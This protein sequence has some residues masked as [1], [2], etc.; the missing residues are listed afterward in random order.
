M[1]AIIIGAGVGG[2]AAASRLSRMGIEVSIYEKR[3]ITGGRLSRLQEK[4]FRIDRGPTLLLMPHLFKEFFSDIGRNIEDYLELT[5]LDPVYR[6][7]F[8]DGSVIEPSAFRKTMVSTISKI[9]KEDAKNYC[10]FISD[11]QKYYDIAM[12]EFIMKNFDSPLDMVTPA[13]LM[14][15]V[16]GGAFRDLYSKTGDYFKD[17]RVRVAFSIQSIYLGERPDSIPSVYGIIP[18]VEFTEGVWY[19]KGGLYSVADALTRVCK[20]EKIKINKGK[21]VKRIII[22]KGEA[23]GIELEDGKKAYADIVISNVDLPHTYLYLVDE[24]Y[25]SHMSDKKVK[26]LATSCSTFMI[27]LGI[28]GKY[29]IAHHNFI[30]PLDFKETLDSIFKTGGIP[31]KPGIYIANP[32]SHDPTLAPKNHSVIY[33]LVP[34][35]NLSGKVN[36]K[37]AKKAFREKI[38]DS[39]SAIGMDDIRERI[40]YER[41]VTP[42]EWEDEFA[43]EKGATFGLSPTLLQSAAFRPPNKDPKI[44][45]LYFVGASTHPGSGLPIVIL[46]SKLLEMRI[47]KDFGV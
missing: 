24:K 25:R 23:K 1:K 3:K 35:S 12:K 28:K 36:W 47:R 15:L 43:L 4:G 10:R 34:V 46:S 8:D 9:N 18:F 7:N 13:G 22:E 38:L 37:K 5:Q 6:M 19:P 17:R 40:V 21:S 42:D 39:L 14:S 44:K 26:S 11:Y 20:E 41:I 32:S 27:Y 45:N 2:M 29:D 30:L 31:E 16:S 33:V